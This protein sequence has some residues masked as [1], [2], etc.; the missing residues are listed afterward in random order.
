[1]AAAVA[2]KVA[3]RKSPVSAKAPAKTRRKIA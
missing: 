2:K 3:A 1:V